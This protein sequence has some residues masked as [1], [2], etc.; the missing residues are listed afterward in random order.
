MGNLL[1]GEI[2]H[3]NAPTRELLLILRKNRRRWPRST[4]HR[5]GCRKLCC[6]L[7]PL[8]KT[9]PKLGRNLL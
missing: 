3:S 4:I 7:N 5:H 6:N 2:K 9:F 1:F 8:L